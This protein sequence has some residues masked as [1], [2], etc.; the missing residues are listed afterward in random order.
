MAGLAMEIY[1]SGVYVFSAAIIATLFFPSGDPI[2]SLILAYSSLAVVGLARPLGGVL[3]G[4]LGDRYGRRLVLSLAV[5]LMSVGTVAIGFLPTYAQVGVLAPVLLLLTRIVM[6]IG[7]GGEFG[8]ASTFMVEHAPAGRKGLYGSF[9]P[10]G[11]VLGA[12]LSAGVVLL[13][14]SLLTEQAYAAWGWR[15]P[16]LLGVIPALVGIYLRFGVEESP[17]FERMEDEGRVVEHPFREAIRNDWKVMLVLFAMVG[18]WNL[19]FNALAGFN[20]GYITTQAGFSLNSAL[21][22]TL[23]GF[24]A[25]AAILPITGSLSDRVGSRPILLGAS[26]ALAVFSYPI[27]LL[28]LQG[29]FASFVAGQVLLSAVIGAYCG[30]IAAAVVQLV[31]AAVRV[32]SISLSHN[33]SVIIV[34]SA[35]PVV[36]LYLAG[37]FDNAAFGVTLW[38][39]VN[40]LI[41]VAGLYAAKR[42]LTR[43]QASVASIAR[44]PVETS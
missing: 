27:Y 22:A 6:G 41:A 28:L 19:G 16:F 37:A 44:E 14:G 23:I 3:L 36:M 38:V 31:P 33:L 20:V 4:S 25:F 10:M 5:V 39:V 2:A 32:T 26:V 7:Y 11:V 9:Y 42:S 8:T 43:E 34:S 21:L 30:P 17:E 24:F 12:V 40:A 1:D 13:V 15:I 29:T 35:T 18:I